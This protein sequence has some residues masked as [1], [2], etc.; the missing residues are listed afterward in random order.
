MFSDFFDALDGVAMTDDGSIIHLDDDEI[1]QADGKDGSV[2]VVTDEDI[3]AIEIFMGADVC[4]AV[5]VRGEQS[6]ILFPV[7]DIVPAESSRDNGEAIDVFHDAIVDRERLEGGPELVE[8]LCTGGC[9]EG[10]GDMFDLLDQSREIGMEGVQDGM[11]LPD[12]HAAIPDIVSAVEVALSGRAI[13]FFDEAEAGEAGMF[14]AV[15]TRF[16]VA[17]VAIAGFG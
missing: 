1:V 7:A 10:I 2:S 6:A 4:D 11:D 16:V 15:A 8:D 3:V 9:F 17:N 13:R 14:E 12:K 5:F